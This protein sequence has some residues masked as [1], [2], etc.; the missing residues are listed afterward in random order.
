MTFEKPQPA[1][2]GNWMGWRLR[3]RGS[4]TAAHGVLGLASIAVSLTVVVMAVWSVTASRRTDGRVDHRFAV[5]RAVLAELL[6]LA[7]AGL[8]GMALLI[9]GSRPADAL[10]LIYGPTA[11]LC[12]PAAIL[13]GT[14]ASARHA[15]RLR[16]DVWTA[17]GGI[18]LLGIGLRLLATG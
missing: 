1:T 13:I 3:Y 9:T 4:V 18:V 5:D 11:V 14:R 10:H 17:G 6:L 15:G 12:L 16:R 8:V 2:R 7:A